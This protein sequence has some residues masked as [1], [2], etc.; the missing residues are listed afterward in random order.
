MTDTYRTAVNPYTAKAAEARAKLQRERTAATE[1]E[2]QREALL[3]E[4]NAGLAPFRVY[5]RQGGT[6]ES[7]TVRLTHPGSG[8]DL[9]ICYEDTMLEDLPRRVGTAAFATVIETIEADIKKREARMAAIRHFAEPV[10]LAIAGTMLTS[11]LRGAFEWGHA[12]FVLVCSLTFNLW[13]F[14]T[15]KR[16]PP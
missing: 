13:L 8:L 4:V 10:G 16:S 14:G 6:F 3:A 15:F 2:A 11:T 12:V 7:N 9:G 5:R 1:L